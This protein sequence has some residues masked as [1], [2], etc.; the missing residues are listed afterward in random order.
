VVWKA[1]ADT[2][3]ED[4]EAVFGQG[5]KIFIA[6][7][8]PPAADSVGPTHIEKAA[9]QAGKARFVFLSR[10]MRKKN[11]NWFL[12]LLRSANGDISL[13]VYGPVEDDEYFE[14]TKQLIA[15]LPANIDVEIKG[16]VEYDRVAEVLAQYEFFVLPTLGENFGHIY[17]EA[18]AA[19]L[20]LLTSDRTPWRDLEG[21]KVGWDIPLEDPG[22]W[23]DVVETCAAMTDEEYRQRC[24]QAL[25]FARGWLSD[26]E[27]N[28][29]NREALRY[30]VSRSGKP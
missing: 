17:V 10:L 6:P 15:K 23:L 25:D 26:P 8:L 12:D 4:I 3:R 14:D 11:V 28:E 13:D 24:Q 21:K 19:G 7:N 29:S 1:A 16:P 5:Q 20:P 27:L 18:M 30:A 2:E 9:K 22:K